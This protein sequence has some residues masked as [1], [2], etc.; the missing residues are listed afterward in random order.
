MA[1]KVRYLTEE[2]I[3]QDAKQLLVEYEETIGMPIELPVPVPEITTYH[4]ALRLGFA[5]LHQTLDIPMLRGQPDV[6]GAIWV[7]TEVVLIDL[8]LDPIRNPAMA[9]RY[10]F[11]VGHEIG[12]WRLHRSYVAKNASQASLFGGSSEPTVIC[13]SSQVTEP[14]E[15]QANIFSSCLLMPRH[16]VH[17]EWQECLGHK[18]PLLLSDLRSNGRVMMRAKPTVYAEGRTEAETVGDALFEEVSK[19]IARR[20]GVSPQAMRIRL[21][22]LGLLLR[23]APRQ[24]SL[25]IS[26]PF[27]EIVEC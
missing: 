18:R 25:Q 26:P 24:T 10:R 8:S 2:E 3:E 4:L 11:S 17:Q 27:Q 9:G 19:P 16:L 14:I 5:D 13:R 6:L 23:Q 7:D 20:F 1:I 15:R 12:H 22:D 21:E